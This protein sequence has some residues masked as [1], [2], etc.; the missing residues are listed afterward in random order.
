MQDNVPE[1]SR[2]GRHLKVLLPETAAL[3][4]R[5]MLMNLLVGRLDEFA[6]V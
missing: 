1:E 6:G 4:L 5:V 2:L 3:R